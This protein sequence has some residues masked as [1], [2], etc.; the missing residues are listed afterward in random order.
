ME[1][2]QTSIIL[3]IVKIVVIGVVAVLVLAE[4]D[5][6]FNDIF[7]PMVNAIKSL[8]ANTIGGLINWLIGDKK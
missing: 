4:F 3:G 5:I 8:W 6:A 2:K 7:A 1:D